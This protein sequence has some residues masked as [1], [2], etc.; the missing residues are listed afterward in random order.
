MSVACLAFTER[1]F[2]LAQKLAQVLGG[3]ADRS[4][5]PVSLQNWTQAHFTK[6]RALIYVGAVGIAVRAVAPYLQSKTTDPAVVVVDECGR[7]AIPLVSGHL[8]GANDLA[9][10]VAELCGA[11]AVITTATDCNGLFAVDEWARCQHCVVMN[12]ACIRKVS[13]ALLA[14]KEIRVKTEHPIVGIPPRGVKVVQ[15]PPYEVYLGNMPQQASVLWLVPKVT[16]LGIGCRKGTGIEALEKV[17]QASGILPQSVCAVASI[18]LKAQEKGLLAFCERH[19]WPF[20]VYRAEEL[21]QAEGTFS[22][23]AF[24]EKTT[25]V[26]NVCERAAV[27]GSGGGSLLC[28]KMVGSGVTLAAAC[29]PVRLDWRFHNV[30]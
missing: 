13:G 19:A 22:G 24:V 17:F 4:G 25:G 5:Q 12:P 27:L 1:G 8:G 2:S 9:R 21:A 20:Q 18:D 23:S 6:D 26:D 15:K 16:V 7:Y 30:W 28:R 29:K 11:Q 10:R 14:G 3:T